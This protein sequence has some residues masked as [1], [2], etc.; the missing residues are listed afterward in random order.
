MKGMM[1]VR[2][3]C[4][5]AYLFPGTEPHFKTCQTNGKKKK[6]RKDKENGHRCMRMLIIRVTATFFVL[7]LGPVSECLLSS[8]LCMMR[9]VGEHLV[10]ASSKMI[11]LDKLLKK[12]LSEKHRILLFSQWTR[13]LDIIEDFMN[14][15]GQSVSQ[16]PLLSVCV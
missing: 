10:Q 13:M 4:D 16:D 9:D 12:L 8:F 14:L 3:C 1:Q 11:V 15:R 2:K 7:L 6:S 5:H